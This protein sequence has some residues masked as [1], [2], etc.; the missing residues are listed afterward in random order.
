MVVDEVLARYAEK[1][2][3]VKERNAPKYPHLAL[4]K[5]LNEYA[6]KLK[7]TEGK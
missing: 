4:Q 6:G 3:F 1:Y 2:S 5:A 7:K